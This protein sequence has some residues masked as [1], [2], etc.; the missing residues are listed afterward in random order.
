MDYESI[1]AIAKDGDLLFVKV[2]KSSFLSNIVSFFTK[3]EFT[4]VGFLFWHNN[5]LLIIESTSKNGLRIANASVYAR[6]GLELVSSPED[7]AYIE[8][9]ALARIGT[10]RYGWFSAFYIGV[11][12]VMLT[13]FDIKLPQDRHNRNKACSEF[14]AEVLDFE[15]VDISPGQLYKIVTK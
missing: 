2:K 6:R 11:R 5:R 10:R 3:S 12:E 13:H 15:D 1:R 8:D 9:A 7:W 14:V 4:H